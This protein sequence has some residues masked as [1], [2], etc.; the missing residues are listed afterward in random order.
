MQQ[1]WSKHARGL[2]MAKGQALTL[3]KTVAK[4]A[5]NDGQSTH[6]NK[7]TYGPKVKAQKGNI[8]LSST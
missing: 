2:K 5:Q 4:S 3:L 6:V 8:S 1:T 7:Q